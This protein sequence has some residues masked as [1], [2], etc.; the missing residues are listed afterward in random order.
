MGKVV[1]KLSVDK[2]VELLDEI[3]LATN[4]EIEVILKEKKEMVRDS[5]IIHANG[6]IDQCRKFIEVMEAKKALL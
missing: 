4:D 6:R 1:E 5:Q 3:I 2:Q